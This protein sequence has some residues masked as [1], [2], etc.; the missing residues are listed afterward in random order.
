MKFHPTQKKVALSSKRFK[1]LNCGRGWGKTEYAVEVAVHK[2]L[3]KG[4]R[5]VLYVA[6]TIQQARDI[7]WSRF[8][9]RC[10]P[11]T[12]KAKESPSLEI[13]I[14]TIDGGESVIVLRG[15]EAVE[16]M[17][18]QEFDYI[19]MDEVASMRNFW[20]GWQ[21][22]LLPTFRMSRGGALFISTP[23][24]FNHFYDLYNMQGKDWESFTFT[25]YDNPFINPEEIEDARESSTEDKFAQEYMADFRKQEGLVYKE[26]NRVAH[27]YEVLPDIKVVEM[28]MPVD[29]GY[30]HPC[31]ALT[32]QVDSDGN[33]YVDNEWY[34]TEKT[35]DEIADYILSQSPQ[36]VYPD[37]EN[38]S[39]IEV[40]RRKG[41]NIREV[42]K[43]KG[44]V[45]TGIGLV[46]EAFL[47]GR[48]K[49]NK[50]CVNLISELETY[51]YPESNSKGIK[52][53]NPE[54]VDDDAL[55]ALRYFIMTHTPPKTFTKLDRMKFN[56]KRRQKQQNTAR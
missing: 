43:G 41:L 51:H 27:T 19:V 55:D 1:V 28:C 14:N 12:V 10:Q 37:P 47:S 13:T 2:A 16:T 44:S 18:G 32:I 31:A 6:P 21:E 49:I 34:K 29:F 53:E 54:K 36:K 15:W 17:R 40:L 30:R 26:F 11:I 20:V 45:Q 42:V 8:K 56:A 7:S 39:A 4:G 25:T 46:R 3:A 22:V 50:T 48:L 38:Q 5:R 35:E 9:E 33:Y 23:K 52:N 24:G